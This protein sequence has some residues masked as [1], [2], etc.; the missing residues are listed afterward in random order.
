MTA[1]DSSQIYFDCNATTPSL[2]EA[3][4]AAM[5]A[6]RS[7]YGNPSS[8]HAS[9]IRAK[10]ILEL[11]RQKAGQ[12]IGCDPSRVVFT[13]GAT[14]GIQ[15]AVL[16]ALHSAAANLRVGR[17]IPTKIL[18][19]ATEHKAVPQAVQH[20]KGVLGLQLEILPI[21]VDHRGC[22]D[23]AFLAEH[24]RDTLLLCTMAVNNETGVISDLAGIEQV[25]RGA[26][27]TALWL[28]DCVQALGKL[29]IDFARHTIDYAPFSGHKLYAPKGIGFLYARDGAP[30]TPLMVGGGQERGLRSGTENLPGVAALGRVLDALITPDEA[31]FHPHDRLSQ[32][33]DAL[34]AS[35]K[36]AFPDIRFNTSFEV[37]VP[38]TINFSVPGISSREMINV[39]DAAGVRMSAG[40]ACSSGK[41]TRS[42]VLDAMNCPEWQSASALR[43]SFGPATSAEEIER[44]CTA[45]LGAAAALRASCMLVN[46]AGFEAPEVWRDGVIQ[47]ASSDSS[48]TWLLSNKTTRECVIIDPTEEVAE[49]IL[50]FVECQHAHVLG[51]LDTHSHADHESPRPVLQ[52]LLRSYMPTPDTAFDPLGWPAEL[53]PIALD[54]GERVPCIRWGR[55]KEQWVLARLATPGH[56]SD[57]CTFLYG[58]TLDGKSLRAQNVRFAFAGD[59]VLIGGLGRTNFVSSD[60]AAMYA[61]L[62]RLNGTLAE[63]TIVCPAHDYDN[64][65]I[66]VWETE[67]RSNELLVLTLDRH[68]LLAKEK[69]F[70]AK[71][72]ID[73]ELAGREQLFQGMVCGVVNATGEAQ[74]RCSLGPGELKPFVQDVA[75]RGSQVLLV[76]VREPSEFAM[77][78]DWAAHGLPQEPK[79]VPLSRLANFVGELLS[80]PSNL[81]APIVFICQSGVRSLQAA[82]SLRRLGFQQIWSVEG[83]MAYGFG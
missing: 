80:N 39:F 41:A 26:S 57:S 63:Q 17:P 83:G 71:Q 27:Q 78:G 76:D 56:T 68:D 12:V 59:M 60:A 23:L 75:G 38:T 8:T 65:F 51:V 5:A 46:R 13:S 45:I 4:E 47:F 48:N 81:A 3:A 79:N 54:S 72:A 16:S 29:P 77:V 31:I 66:T 21:P 61:S 34:V 22:H 53:E 1:R 55:A 7:F 32:F 73:L 10:H 28:V 67:R 36:Q 43:L 82:K 25:L 14:E 9:G 33:R 37:A 58:T 50:H 30:L 74:G 35:L 11:T 69:F 18:Y 19:G 64:T 49:R 44:G 2:P 42:Y 62:H 6:M 52:T 70:A 24:A 40:S 15:I 20:W